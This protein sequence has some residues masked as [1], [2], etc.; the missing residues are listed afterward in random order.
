VIYIGW[1]QQRRTTD[2]SP[3]DFPPFQDEFV[4]EVDELV[5]MTDPSVELEEIWRRIMEERRR[6]E[7]AEEEGVEDEIVEEEM[8]IT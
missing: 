8:M 3:P 7:E 2:Y 5:E 1:G 6:A 4:D